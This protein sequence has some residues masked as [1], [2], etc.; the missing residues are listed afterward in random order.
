MKWISLIISSLW[1]VGGIYKTAN[2]HVVLKVYVLEAVKM[3]K[4]KDLS[5][6]QIVIARWLGQSISKTAALVGCPRSAVV[7]IY[8][9][10]TKEGI[11]MNWQQGHGLLMH[12]G[13]KGWPVLSDCL[14]GYIAADQSGFPC[15]P[16]STTKIANNRHMSI[17]TGPQSSGRSW[18]GLMNHVFFYI[19]WM[20]GCLCITH[21]GNTWH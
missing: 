17:I 6:G 13:S 12:T 3:D 16:V 5:K 15:W 8:Q 4:S 20:A 1:L 14:W 21:L 7:S 9:M 2:E 10:C 11:V 18:P 19:M